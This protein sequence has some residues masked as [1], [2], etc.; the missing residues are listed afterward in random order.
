MAA[1]FDPAT[2]TDPSVRDAA[3]ARVNK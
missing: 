1:K 3:L 2:V